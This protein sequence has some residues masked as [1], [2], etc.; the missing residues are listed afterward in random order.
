MKTVFFPILFYALLLFV[1]PVSAV[2]PDNISSYHFRIREKQWLFSTDFVMD[3]DGLCLGK[4]V[5]SSFQIP[6]HYTL[7]DSRGEQQATAVYRILNLSLF[8]SWASE[9]DIYDG[10]GLPIGYIDGQV[11]TFQ[12]ARFSIYCR[13]KLVAIAYLDK[14][15]A[16]F[17][18]VDAETESRLIANF[19]RHFVK[20]VTD[21]WSVDV[22]DRTT[23]LPEVIKI[24]AAFAIDTQEYFKE[25]T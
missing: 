24:F 14:Q 20:D 13:G 12:A 23:V 25:D 10:D 17:S 9:I 4:V 22:Y 3:T 19:T 21:H 8:Y 7:Y 1:D 11:G 16:S 5:K 15:R 2:T 18:I 6:T